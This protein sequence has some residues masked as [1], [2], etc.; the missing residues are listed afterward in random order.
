MLTICLFFRRGATTR[1]DLSRKRWFTNMRDYS[2]FYWPV[3]NLPPG[4][5]QG[6]ASPLRVGIPISVYSF[7]VERLLFESTEIHYKSTEFTRNLKKFLE[8][9]CF[10]ALRFHEKFYPN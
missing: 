8:F 2:R 7:R 5:Y 4:N 9:G 10:S 1:L 6:N 3:I